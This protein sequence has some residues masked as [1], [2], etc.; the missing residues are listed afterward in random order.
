M[1]NMLILINVKYMYSRYRDSVF[2]LKVY[3]YENLFDIV[4]NLWFLIM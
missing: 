4:Y 1:R 3:V 2:F